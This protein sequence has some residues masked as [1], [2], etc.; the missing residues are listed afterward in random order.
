MFPFGIASTGGAVFH[1]LSGAT[2]AATIITDGT[3]GGSSFLRS[4]Q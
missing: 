3:T 2:L 1:S 4:L